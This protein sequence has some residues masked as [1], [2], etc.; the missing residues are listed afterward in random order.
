[1]KPESPLF[2]SFPG[3]KSTLEYVQYDLENDDGWV[4]GETAFEEPSA[5]GEI[6]KDK[7]HLK[8]YYC[9]YEPSKVSIRYTTLFQRPSNVH[10]VHITFD[11]R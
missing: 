6:T 7:K 1:M 4:A 5:Y 3:T 10:N 11:E 8:L 2:P 9:Y